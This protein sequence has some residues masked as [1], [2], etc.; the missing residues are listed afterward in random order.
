MRSSRHTRPSGRGLAAGGPA[1]FPT[2]MAGTA[3]AGSAER[4][5][6]RYAPFIT[7]SLTPRAE[8]MVRG[9]HTIGVWTAPER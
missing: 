2:D 6:R 9:R 3:T 1:A 4:L 7:G 5:A 8:P